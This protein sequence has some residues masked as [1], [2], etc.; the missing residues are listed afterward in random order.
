MCI[1]IYLFLVLPLS[2]CIRF[3]VII[4]DYVDIRVTFLLVLNHILD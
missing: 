3:L 1:F 2:V 4:F